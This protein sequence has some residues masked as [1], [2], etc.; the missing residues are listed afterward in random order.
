M[1][2]RSGSRALP[3]PRN[4]DFDFD[5]FTFWNGAFA[6]SANHLSAPMHGRS[7]GGF[8]DESDYHPN[9]RRKN[10]HNCL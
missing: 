2:L 4:G 8:G 3:T 7:K 10:R 6:N 9:D 1:V 5:K